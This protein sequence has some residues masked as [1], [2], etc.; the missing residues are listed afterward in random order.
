MCEM[1]SCA[2]V[3]PVLRVACVVRQG[4]VYEKE[5]RDTFGLA[6]MECWFTNSRNKHVLFTYNTKDATTKQKK[7]EK[8][9]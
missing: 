1:R 3:S 8:G 9:S 5:W 2:S 7:K 4:T 6:I